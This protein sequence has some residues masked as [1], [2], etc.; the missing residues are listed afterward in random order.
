MG[1]ERAEYRR[2]GVN[3]EAYTLFVIAT[4]GQNTEPQYFEGLQSIANERV[5]IE[6]LQRRKSDSAPKYIFQ[7][8]SRF[9]SDYSLRPTDELWMV[10][11][12]DLWPDSSLSTVAQECKN[13]RFRLAVSNPSFE[14]WLLLHLKDIE[15]YSV[16][17]RLELQKNPKVN[18]NRTKLERELI[19]LCQGY[20]KSKLKFDTFRSGIQK[21][22]FR[23]ERLHVNKNER[24]PQSL[25]SHVYILVK[26][27]LT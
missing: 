13:K 17:E 19:K 11:D 20:N 23:A 5:Y 24:W 14:L 7:Q 3:R 4:E 10:I 25:G 21:A 12:R 27:I 15:E 6:I 8:L 26:K 2:R 18:K 1:R 9:K 16:S 22:I